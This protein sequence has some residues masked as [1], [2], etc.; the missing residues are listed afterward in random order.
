MSTPAPRAPALGWNWFP[1][2]RTYAWWDG[3]RYTTWARDVDGVWHYT[4][5]SRRRRVVWPWL[6]VAFLLGIVG[7][8]VLGALVSSTGPNDGG[9]GG[10]LGELLFDDRYSADLTE[11]SGDF[12]AA[13][14][15][16]YAGRYA[17]DG[18]H[19]VVREPDQWAPVAVRASMSHSVLGAEVE[20]ATV[21]APEDAAFG[22]GCWQDQ[23][24][25]YIFTVASSGERSVVEIRDGTFEVIA[26]RAGPPPT[27]GRTDRLLLTCVIGGIGIEAD[28]VELTGYVNGVKAVDATSTDKTSEI[29]HTGFAGHTNVAVPAEWRVTKFWRR[30]PDE[31]PR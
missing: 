23:E 7:L 31:L 10:G 17:P 1:D 29:R 28:N 24:H 15:G 14:A 5:G 21:S 30:G 8:M 9:S 3:N 4:Y 2:E 13:D 20:A 11:G 12:V 27:P 18:Y 26:R 16:A 25:G 22:P 6:V 19:L